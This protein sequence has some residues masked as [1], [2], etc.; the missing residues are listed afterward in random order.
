[1]SS[2]IE[3]QNLKNK[4]KEIEKEPEYKINT[5]YLLWACF[6]L[7]IASC[8]QVGFCIGEAGQVGLILAEKLNWTAQGTKVI[9]NSYLANAGTLGIALGCLAGSKIILMW[10]DRNLRGLFIIINLLQIFANALKLILNFYPILIGRFI[11][12]FLSGV[13]NLCF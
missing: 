9:N 4:E 8:I 7:L 1:M 6:N 10:G 12:G 13:L 3:L 2:E 11:F 5:C